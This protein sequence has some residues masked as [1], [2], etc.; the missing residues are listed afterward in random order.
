MHEEHH[1]RA[2]GDGE[3]GRHGRAETRGHDHRA[4]QSRDERRRAAP[5]EPREADRQG[6]EI[7]QHPG[8]RGR[9][10]GGGKQG[11]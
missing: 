6:G 8:K 2:D 4:D 9:G 3:D 1:R 7:E 5:A 10:G 11:R